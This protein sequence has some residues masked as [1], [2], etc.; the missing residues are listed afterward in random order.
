MTNT[1]NLHAT[2]A[3]LMNS[4]RVWWLVGSSLIYSIIIGLSIVWNFFDISHS[5]VSV[6]GIISIVISLA[7]VWWVWTMHMARLY[8]DYR[9]K[10]YAVLH[11]ILV[12][13]HET[14]KLSKELFS[15]HTHN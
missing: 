10:E 2:D 3:K 9:R 6:W 1:I 14:R 7:V 13:I 8:L 11:D 15:H 12:D 4:R 5:Y